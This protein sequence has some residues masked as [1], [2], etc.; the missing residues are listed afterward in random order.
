MRSQR[1]KAE[2]ALPDPFGLLDES[3]RFV[4]RHARSHH[5]LAYGQ[6][7]EFGLGIG[8]PFESRP[9][10]RLDSPHCVLRATR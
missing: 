5:L 1:G 2:R 4:L 9:L 7:F 10:P 8:I 3:I 6:G